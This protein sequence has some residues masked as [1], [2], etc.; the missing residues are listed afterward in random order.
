[1]S[2]SYKKQP[3]YYMCGDDKRS[4]LRDRRRARRVV[5]RKNNELLRN[6]KDFEEY[7]HLVRLECSCNDV[8]NWTHDGRRRLAKPWESF[9]PAIVYLDD[10][11]E[12]V[13]ALDGDKFP[14]TEGTSQKKHYEWY[15][16]L[17]RK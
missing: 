3:F 9:P 2:R 4:K 12:V 14:P 16:T 8:W 17:F 11:D 13:F 1:M 15:L 5:R 6:T 7:S 10:V